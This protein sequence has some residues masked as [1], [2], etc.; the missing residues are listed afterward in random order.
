M[1]HS[2]M[3]EVLTHDKHFTQEGFRI[4]PEGE[5]ASDHFLDD[6]TEFV[7]QSYPHRITFTPP[8][9]MNLAPTVELGT[10]LR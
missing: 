8:S 9:L 10:S 7:K 5:Q 3:T 1:T 6:L 4:L 2:K